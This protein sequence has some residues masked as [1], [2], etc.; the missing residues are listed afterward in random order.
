M[1]TATPSSN[2][3]YRILDFHRLVQI[4]ERHELYFARPTAWADPYEH[5]VNKFSDSV[6]AQCWCQIGVSDAM[7]RIYSPNGLGVRVSTTRSK[8]AKVLE[9]FQGEH[10]GCEVVCKPVT[11]HSQTHIS[12][13]LA[14]LRKLDAKTDRYLLEPLFNK[15]NPFSH[16]AEWRAAIYCPDGPKEEK[17]GLRVPVDPHALF[18]NILFDPRAPKEL[19]A[20]LQL[21]LAQT[22]GFKKPMGPSKLYELPRKSLAEK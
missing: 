15:R 13:R 1:D 20:A 6:F 22:V 8:L 16:E 12:Q 17:E 4:F 19:V 7:W 21:Y 3:L 5:H 14:N 18:S 10:K 2:N 9:A 11:Y